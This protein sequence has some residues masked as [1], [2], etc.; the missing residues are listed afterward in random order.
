MSKP[1][2]G[3]TPGLQDDEVYA[4]VH[5]GYM[6]S[7]TASGGLPVLL[8][9]SSDP[10]ILEESIARCDG[11]VFSGGADVDPS[12]YGE[13]PRP[14]CGSISPLRDEMELTL[15]RMLSERRDRPVLAICRGMQVMN[16]ALGGDLYQDLPTDYPHDVIAHRQHQ[17]GQYPSH[18]V[19]VTMSSPLDI[20]VHTGTIRVN[21]LHHQAIRRLGRGL[22]P[23]GVAPDGVMEAIYLQEH[24]FFLGVQWHP[25]RMYSHDDASRALFSAFVESCS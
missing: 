20:I 1:L 8:P 11:I 9:L 12:V 3:I 5:R 24:P 14:Q 19:I 4:L 10:A 22:V 23:C 18:D 2:I 17:P 7:I 13:F 21:S 15:L 25:E 16:V 6:D